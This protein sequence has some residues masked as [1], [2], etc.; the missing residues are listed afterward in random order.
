MDY[1]A[2]IEFFNTLDDDAK[3]KEI[4]AH[5]GL[6]VYYA[7]VLEEQAIVMI[8]ICRQVK[9]KLTTQGQVDNLWDD[10]HLGVRTLGMLINEIKQ[11]YN[12]SDNDFKELKNVLRFRNYITHDYFRLNIELFYSDLGQKRMIKDFI[13]FRDRAK[14]LD[15]KLLQY[16][17]I[18]SDK[19]GMSPERIDEIMKQ[20]IKEWKK[21]N[22]SDDYK[23]IIK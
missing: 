19:I 22:I 9:N 17:K 13:E 12:I 21:K 23:T 14:S 10:Y 5:F 11:L 6:A 4:Y 20:T 2:T 15:D 3:A 1:K 18:Y 7:Q 16:L 8:A